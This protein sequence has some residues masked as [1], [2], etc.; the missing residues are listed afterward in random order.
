MAFINDLRTKSACLNTVLNSCTTWKDKAFI[1]TEIKE[2][3]THWTYARMPSVKTSIIVPHDEL[4]LLLY[5]D[6]VQTWLVAF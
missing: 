4:R 5:S 2:A 3:L 1:G 6:P